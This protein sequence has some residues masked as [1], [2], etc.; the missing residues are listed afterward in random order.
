MALNPIAY[1]E[2]DFLVFDEAHTF[3]GALGSETACLIRRLRAFCG[4]D[5]D[6]S[7]QPDRTE[8]GRDWPEPSGI[9]RARRMPS[10]TR[11]TCVATSATIVDRQDPQAAKHF[12]SRFFGVAPE[13]VET[14]GEDYEAEVWATPRSVPPAPAEDPAEILERCVRAVEDEDG[15]G[16]AVRAVWRSLRGEDLGEGNWPEWCCSIAS[17]ARA[18]MMETA[19][20]MHVRRRCTSAA[21]AGPRI[22]L[23]FRDAGHVGQRALPSSCMRC[24][25]AARA[26]IPAH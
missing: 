12:A 3:T 13:E 7:A 8:P 9:E 23:A 1:T 10:G 15:S 17:S 14:V 20:H 6:A 25:R 18:T 16:S 21:T 26:R 2:L 5:V 11:T 22:P 4:G 19:F 24:D